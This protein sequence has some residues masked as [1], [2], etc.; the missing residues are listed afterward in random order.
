M[1][2]LPGEEQQGAGKL[3]ASLRS[4]HTTKT[5]A[6]I[7]SVSFSSILRRRALGNVWGKKG[8]KSKHDIC[9]C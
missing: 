7:I 2:Q 4:W 8:V 1:V 3:V 5:T 6:P 9:Y